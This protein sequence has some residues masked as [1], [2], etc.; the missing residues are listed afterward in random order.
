[1]TIIKVTNKRIRFEHPIVLDPDKKYALGVSHLM[2]SLNQVFRIGNFYFDVYIP[3][4]TTT[5]RFMFKGG[6]AGTFTIKDLEKELQ[7]IM[8]NTYYLLIGKMEKDKKT[9][10]VKALKSTKITP[11]KFKVKKTPDDYVLVLNVPFL[12][13]VV[14]I[15]DFAKTFKFE[16]IFWE[17]ENII[18][19]TDYLSA[20]IE[21]ILKPLSVIKWHCNIAEFSYAGHDSHPHLHK[22]EELLHISFINN[23]FYEKPVYKEN[24]R[25]IM[26]VPLRKGLQEIREVILTPL[27]DKSRVIKSL[28][29][30][31]VYLHLKET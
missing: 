2:F 18:P 31:T 23:N 20:N 5:E 8:Q 27:N 4:P 9:E 3:I 24:L 6:L 1:M 21:E 12:L 14:S 25:K 22:Q 17:K 13:T 28:R 26:F 15:G 30:V 29:N 11:A 10:I 16:N 19:N 7:K